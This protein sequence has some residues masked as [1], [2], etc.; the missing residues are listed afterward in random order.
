MD[1]AA[2]I[3]IGLAQA[4]INNGIKTILLPVVTA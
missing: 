1:L 3:R 2:I 4:A